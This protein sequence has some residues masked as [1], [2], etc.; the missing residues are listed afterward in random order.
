MNEL[1]WMFQWDFYRNQAGL[2]RQVSGVKI[3]C[4]GSFICTSAKLLSNLSETI[5]RSRPASP[6]RYSEIHTQSKY[7]HEHARARLETKQSNCTTG[8]EGKIS[9]LLEI[10]KPRGAT[11]DAFAGYKVR[12]APAVLLWRGHATCQIH[13]ANGLITVWAPSLPRQMSH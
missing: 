9:N 13:A 7:K 6:V 4:L 5:T 3:P 12:A 8:Q 1:T 2:V 10:A 11:A